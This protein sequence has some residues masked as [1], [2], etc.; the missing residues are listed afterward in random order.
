MADTAHPTYEVTGQQFM[1]EPDGQ[2]GYH[3][4]AHVAFRTPSGTH[5]HVKVQMT[6]YTARNVHDAIA[7]H[8]N[9]IEQVNSL[10]Q[11]P[12]PPHET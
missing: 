7:R 5:A 8:Q 11:G 6:H 2:G 12:P 1:T 9:R 3:E 4:V 10:G